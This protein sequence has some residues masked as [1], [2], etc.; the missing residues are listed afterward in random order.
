MIAP[1]THIDQLIE[2][3]RATTWNAPALIS[4]MV[5]GWVKD[6]TLAASEETRRRD[7]AE[8]QQICNTIFEGIPI[9]AHCNA[10]FAWLPFD[11]A[12]RAKPIVSR[13]KESGI[14]V[15][16]AEPYATTTAVPQALRLAFGGVPKADLSR[17]VRKSLGI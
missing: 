3:I 15:S 13:L 6:G 16:G 7:G 9:V 8:C 14:L 12:V 4:G 11:Q 5:T 1:P 17:E 10:G 2:A